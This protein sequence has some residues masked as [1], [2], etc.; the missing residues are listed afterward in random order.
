LEDFRDVHVVNGI[1]HHKRVIDDLTYMKENGI[2]T[3]VALQDKKSRCPGCGTRLYWFSRA[4][5]ACGTQI[6]GAEH[7]RF[8]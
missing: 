4:C 5:P 6:G 1:S 8:F 2:G 3:W 7:A